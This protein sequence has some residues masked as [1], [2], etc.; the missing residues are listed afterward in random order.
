MS[1]MTPIATD[2]L[3]RSE[4]TL[5][6][7]SRH[8][9]TDAAAQQTR[10]PFGDFPRNLVSRHPHHFVPCHS[11]RTPALRNPSVSPLFEVCFDAATFRSA[12]FHSKPSSMALLDIAQRQRRLTSDPDAGSGIVRLNL[13]FWKGLEAAMGKSSLGAANVADGSLADKPSHAK[14]YRCLFLSNSGQNVAVPRMSALCQ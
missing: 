14:F 6:A 3:R 13:E 12:G 7:N 2:L 4:L 5:Y 11:S 9:Y 1:A 8:S 10:N